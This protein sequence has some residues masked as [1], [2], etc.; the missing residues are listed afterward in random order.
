MPSARAGRAEHERRAVRA[1]PARR[2][3]RAEHADL[4]FL[5]IQNTDL[6]HFASL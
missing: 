5:I 3:E 6:K 4:F 1:M 2:A